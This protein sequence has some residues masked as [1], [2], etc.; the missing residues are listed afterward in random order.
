[1]V[2]RGLN[3]IKEHCMDFLNFDLLE[4]EVYLSVPFFIKNK[5]NLIGLLYLVF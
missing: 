5:P 4:L 3:R 1:M 2:Q